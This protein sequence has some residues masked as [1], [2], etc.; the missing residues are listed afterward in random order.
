MKNSFP[1]HSNPDIP[2][3]IHNHVT[4]KTTHRMAFIRNIVKSGELFHVRIKNINAIIGCDPQFFIL[5]LD[6]TAKDIICQYSF[7]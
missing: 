6:N 3:I 5:V 7:G 2:I 4:D 1:I